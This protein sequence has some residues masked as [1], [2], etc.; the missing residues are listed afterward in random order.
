MKKISISIV[1]PLY[2]KED[3]IGRAIESV[4]C[5][6]YNLFELIIINDGS[7]DNSLHIAKEYEYDD[8]VKVYSIPNQGVSFARNYGS[9]IA[10]SEYICFLDG[11]DEWHHENLEEI[12][13]LILNNKD[14]VL[15]STRSYVEGSLKK[16]DMMNKAELTGDFFED[17]SKVN[18]LINSSSACVRKEDF[19][20][21]KGFPVGFGRGEDIYVWF[22]LALLGKTAHSLRTLVT[23]HSDG[24]SRCAN[25]KL[26]EI[27]YHIYYFTLR[28][29]K[30]YKS[31]K[32]IYKSLK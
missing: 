6:K 9:N 26:K 13:R 27:P 14:S 8:R 18:Y 17:Y 24:K 7:T 23:V 4:L 12:V 15:F 16:F 2:N 5:Q 3:T 29:S 25:D 28:N 10:F 11:D 22:R 1:I 21:I 19:K 31:K 32:F 30:I 20:A